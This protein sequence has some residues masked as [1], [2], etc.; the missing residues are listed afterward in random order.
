VFGPLIHAIKWLHAES[1]TY[2]Y[3]LY[4]TE[5]YLDCKEKIDQSYK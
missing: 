5:M 3:D 1:L 4:R 2:F